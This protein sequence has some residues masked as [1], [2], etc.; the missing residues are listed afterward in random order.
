MKSIF[1]WLFELNFNFVNV[2]IIIIITNKT[3]SQDWFKVDFVFQG[4]HIV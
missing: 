2:R 4:Q 1:N 3:S